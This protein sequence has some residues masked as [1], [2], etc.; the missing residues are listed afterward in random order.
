MEQA[1]RANGCTKARLVWVLVAFGLSVPQGC[2]Q[3]S[4]VTVDLS[5]SPDSPIRLAV[6]DFN[7]K[8]PAG[9]LTIGH[10]MVSPPNAGEFIADVTSIRLLEVEGFEV[11]ERSRIARLLEEKDLSQSDLVKQGRY[12]EIGEFL[13]VDYLVLGTVNTYTVAVAGVFAV[14]VVSFSCRCVE[15]KTSKVVWGLAGKNEMPGA[16]PAKSLDMI[17]DEAIPKLNRLLKSRRSRN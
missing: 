15:V 14:N 4:R 7:W 16:E 8:P 5:F 10:T 9:H 11:F 6:L 13:K 1:I 17:L 12:Q 2:A 3:L